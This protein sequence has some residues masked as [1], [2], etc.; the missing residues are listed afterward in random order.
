MCWRRWRWGGISGYPTAQIREAISGYTPSNSRSQLIEKD[1]N[2][3][4]LDAYNANPSS[5][6]AAIEN[7][8][9]LD[10]AGKADGAGR[11]KVLILGGHGRTWA[12]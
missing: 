4:I 10:A 12:G 7:F 1:G 5:M 2:H 3:I 11:G 8:A 6:R 9:R